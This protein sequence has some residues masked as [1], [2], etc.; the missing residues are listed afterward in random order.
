MQEIVNMM[1]EI[2]ML[3]HT[4]R[5]GFAF[6]GTGKQSVADHTYRMTVIAYMLADF[7]KEPIN[8]QKLLLMCL[9]HDLP[10][11]R[12]GD[13]NYVNK[14]YVKTDLKKV[15]GDIEKGSSYGPEIAG[16]INEYEE[17]KTIESLIA[18][19]ADQLELLL[20]LKEELDKGN[21]RANDWFVIAA[22]RLKT[23]MAIKIA[24]EILIRPFDA[25]WIKDKEDLHWINGSKENC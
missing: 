2:G 22:K 11:A 1:N 8:L 23:E 15:I 25:W 5:S 17:K 7:C 20:V 21:S 3:A 18:H 6:L 9:F 19:D 12:T 13:H 4:P 24:D 16:Y 14:R 10:E